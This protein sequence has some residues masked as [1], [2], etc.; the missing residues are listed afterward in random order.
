MSSWSVASSFMFCFSWGKVA[1]T[2]ICCSNLECMQLFV[3]VLL[4]A[5]VAW[6]LWTEATLTFIFVMTWK[7]LIER[8]DI[9]KSLLQQPVHLLWKKG[10][11]NLRLCLVK[12]RFV[13]CNLEIS[14][15]VTDQE[16]CYPVWNLKGH[17]CVHESL[18]L[19][20]TEPIEYIPHPISLRLILI[21][22]VCISKFLQACYMSHPFH[23]FWF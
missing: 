12:E 22:K 21:S 3:Y 8:R 2:R 18:T 14:S 1:G 4:F 16:I 20:Y 9:R 11:R 10:W 23:P 6:C 17:Y 13:Q 19:D 7:I 5:F 15:H